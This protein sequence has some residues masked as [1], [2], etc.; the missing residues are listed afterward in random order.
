MGIFDI[1]RSGEAD[2]EIFPSFFFHKIDELSLSSGDLIY[3]NGVYLVEHEICTKF[4]VLR[5]KLFLFHFN[6]LIVSKTPRAV[7]TTTAARG[8]SNGPS[9][10]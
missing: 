6:I 2:F 3:A 10:D 5:L 7:H 8:K 1:F 9:L 4:D